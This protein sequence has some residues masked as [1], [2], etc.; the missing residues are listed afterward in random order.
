MPAEGHRR[1]VRGAQAVYASISSNLLEV[2]AI[3]ITAYVMLDMR[4][5]ILAKRGESFLLRGD[6]KAT[7]AWAKRYRGRWGGVGT[8][9]DVD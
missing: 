8:G 9:R 1:T 6:Y 2:M 3:V 5:E 7:I 4:G